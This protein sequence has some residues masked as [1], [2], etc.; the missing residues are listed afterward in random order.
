MV[1]KKNRH[2]LEPGYELHWYTIQDILGQGGFGITYLAH[3]SNLKQSVA[4][5]EY[6]PAGIAMREQDSTVQPISEDQ[7]PGFEWGLE[8]FL[9][10]ART[11]TRFDHSNIVRVLT[12]FELNRTAYM[13]MRYEHGQGLDT[14]LPRQATLGEKWLKKMIFP[15]IGGL[16]TVH[17]EGFIHRDIKPPNIFIREDNSPVLIDFGSA[18]QA[19]GQET[20]T[21]TAMISPGYAPFE[22]YHAKS[23]Q[24][25]PWTDI[26]G[27]GATLYRAVTGITPVD[28]LKRSEYLLGD[29]P[30][31]YLSV[32]ELAEGNYSAGFLNAIDHAMAFRDKDRPQTL[33]QWL[34]EINDATAVAQTARTAAPVAPAEI[35]EPPVKLAQPQK[36]K[37]FKLFRLKNFVIAGLL[38]FVFVLLTSQPDEPGDANMPDGTLAD[39]NAENTEQ[40]ANRYK[41]VLADSPDNQAAQSALQ[42]LVEYHVAMVE[43]AIG[44]EDEQTAR[45][46]FEQALNAAPDRHTRQRIRRRIESLVDMQ[47]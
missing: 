47:Q 41:R 7:R 27:L 3:D 46:H 20:C 31:P 42:T 12:V 26:Y 11:L 32:H 21:L 1:Y 16:H 38:L 39:I 29:K 33:K 17:A 25:G 30:D 44:N 23:D 22:Q 8:R 18:R 10:E 24:Q 9:A 36:K 4:I 6:L 40:I 45:H 34:Q 2:A 37:K 14:M 5:K 35:K 43:Q 13:V 19:L 28:A 15:I